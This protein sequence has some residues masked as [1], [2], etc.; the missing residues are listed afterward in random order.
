MT[1]QW[2]T[3]FAFLSSPPQVFTRSKV[4]LETSLSTYT[5]IPALK[6]TKLKQQLNHNLLRFYTAA[7]AALQVL[8]WTLAKQH[9]INIKIDLYCIK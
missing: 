3:P 2:P 9:K 5:Y 6:S 4:L 8:V 1:R 7:L